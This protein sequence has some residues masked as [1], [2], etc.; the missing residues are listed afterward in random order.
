VRRLRLLFFFMVLTN[1]QQAES[2]RRGSRLA[3]GVLLSVRRDLAVQ[4][5]MQLPVRRGCAA[6]CA[7]GYAAG[8]V[9]GCAAGCAAGWMHFG[10]VDAFRRQN[11]CGPGFVFFQ[12]CRPLSCPRWISLVRFLDAVIPAFFLRDFSRGSMCFPLF[13]FI[14]SSTQPAATFDVVATSAI[15]GSFRRALQLRIRSV[16]QQRRFCFPSFHCHTL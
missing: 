16:T 1:C 14:S 13:I 6:G 8:Y 7:A 15:H 5:A 12:T 11:S 4:Q 10:C 2:V 3:S 9:A